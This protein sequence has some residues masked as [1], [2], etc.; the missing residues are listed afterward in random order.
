M[1][2]DLLLW[3]PIWSS[4]SGSDATLNLPE[5]HKFSVWQQC[6]Q[7]VY[8]I[9]ILTL[10]PNNSTRQHRNSN[11]LLH[12]LRQKYLLGVNFDEKLKR[13]IK[14]TIIRHIKNNKL[15][16]NFL[17]K[18]FLAYIHLVRVDCCMLRNKSHVEHSGN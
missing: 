2:G 13:I 9:A 4:R 14:I 12:L 18:L 15:T 5:I 3:L 6:N 10:H 16:L 1:A 17:S 11:N 8:N 7:S